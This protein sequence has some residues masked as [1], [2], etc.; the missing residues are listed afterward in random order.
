MRWQKK[1]KNEKQDELT[2]SDR[3]TADEPVLTTPAV[4]GTAAA[5]AIT[6]AKTMKNF[7]LVAE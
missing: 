2:S 4:Y 6:A 1:Y 7:I 5:E 3:V